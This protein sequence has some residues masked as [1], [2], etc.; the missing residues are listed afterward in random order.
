M[1]VDHYGPAPRATLRLLRAEGD[2]WQEVASGDGNLEHVPTQ[3]GAYRAE[4]RKKSALRMLDMSTSLVRPQQVQL[5]G[6]GGS[7]GCERGFQVNKGRVLVG[8]RAW[9]GV[10]FVPFRR[11][12]IGGMEQRPPT[13]G[14]ESS[15]KRSRLPTPP[16]GRTPSSPCLGAAS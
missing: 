6:Q 9:R 13:Q 7:E 14:Q 8:R 15:G 3:T 11:T 4:V 12:W 10:R 1:R 2:G 5:P 16:R